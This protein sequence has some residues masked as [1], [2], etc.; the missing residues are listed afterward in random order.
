MFGQNEPFLRENEPF[1]FTVYISH[2]HMGLCRFTSKE[3]RAF[4]KGH[5]YVQSSI[6]NFRL[7]AFILNEINN[8]SI[9]VYQPYETP[10]F[11]QI[12]EYNYKSYEMKYYA[13]DIIKEDWHLNDLSRIVYR[14]GIG[15]LNSPQI[16]GRV[17]DLTDDYLIATSLE[18]KSEYP[19]CVS[20]EFV[21]NHSFIT[22]YYNITGKIFKLVLQSYLSE[23]I[24][25]FIYNYTIV[26]P[27]SNI[28]ENGTIPILIKSINIDDPEDITSI[29]TY[30]NYIYGYGA[31]IC[32]VIE[33]TIQI[34]YDEDEMKDKFPEV[35][36]NYRY[37]GRLYNNLYPSEH[38]TKFLEQQGQI[39][40]GGRNLSKRNKKCF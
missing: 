11:P 14:F 1:I 35:N 7:G 20:I 31:Y 13:Y 27:K 39:T 6:I 3:Y 34:M 19:N 38:L 36:Q 10:Y 24:E 37:I 21:C 29:G 16:C 8:P 2:S 28:N 5:D 30:G 17:T 9:K 22:D 4:G 25:I 18:L 23:N 26:I 40:M 32:K 12:N 33:Y 15:V